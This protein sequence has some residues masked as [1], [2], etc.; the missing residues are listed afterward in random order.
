LPGGYTLNKTEH[1]FEVIQDDDE[2]NKVKC[3]ECVDGHAKFAHPVKEDLLNVYFT[4]Q[5]DAGKDIVVSQCGS[6]D[7]AKRL[8]EAAQD[9][10]AHIRFSE[11]VL[12]K[13]EEKSPDI[14]SR[15]ADILD[16]N[17]SDISTNK[18]RRPG[19]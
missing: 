19:V 18:K 17:E 11:D 15:I 14:R 4:A 9:V 1:G 7:D 10:G 13:L 3:F 12:R 8:A 2:G 16:V 6:V 5:R